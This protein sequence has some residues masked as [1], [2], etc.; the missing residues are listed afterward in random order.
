MNSPHLIQICFDDNDINSIKPLV[1]A[2]LRNLSFI[3]FY[4]NFFQQ[5]QLKSLNRMKLNK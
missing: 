3:S 4:N 1:K 2:D 5:D